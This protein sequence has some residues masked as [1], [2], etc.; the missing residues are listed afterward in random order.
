MTCI[1]AIKEPNIWYEGPITKIL[2]S[3]FCSEKKNKRNPREIKT[4]TNVQ[5][6]AGRLI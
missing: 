4:H 2:S 3:D 5:T 6:L 1:Q